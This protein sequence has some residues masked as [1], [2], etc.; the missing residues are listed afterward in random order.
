MQ[1]NYEIND[2][3]VEVVQLPVGYR[4]TGST[5]D[6]YQEMLNRYF[7]YRTNLRVEKSGGNEVLL[8][9]EMECRLLVDMSQ[10]NDDPAWLT[11]FFRYGLDR[12]FCLLPLKLGENM[13]VWFIYQSSDEYWPAYSNHVHS[14]LGLRA[15]RDNYVWHMS[16]T[17]L[18]AL[19]V[20]GDLVVAK[21]ATKC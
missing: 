5:R 9:T 10:D 21:E 16:S 17:F 18:E 12:G 8:L 13:F 3:V 1:I 6:M 4:L 19:K 7:K 2:R 14:S 11:A 20:V 15:N